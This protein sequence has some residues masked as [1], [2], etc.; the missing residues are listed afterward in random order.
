MKLENDIVLN[1]SDGATYSLSE[2][3]EESIDWWKGLTNQRYTKVDYFDEGSEAFILVAFLNYLRLKNIQL[4]YDMKDSNDIN[5]ASGEDL[6]RIGLYYGVLRKEGT[7][8]TLNA[9]LTLKSPAKETLSFYEGVEAST[10]DSVYFQNSDLIVIN[11][12]EQIVD[13]S[14]TA[15]DTG[16]FGNILAGTLINI[17]SDLGVEATITNITAG[18]DGTSEEDDETYRARIISSK[19]FYPA[20]SV[21]WYTYLAQEV[22]PRAKYVKTSNNSGDIYY[23]YINDYDKLVD[24]FNDDK[25]NI[26]YIN[27]SYILAEELSV[28]EN[29]TLN[30]SAIQGYDPTQLVTDILGVFE[31]YINSVEI[32]GTIDKDYLVTLLYGV[33][34]LNSL[35]P[36]VLTSISL[37]NNQYCTLASTFSVN[38]LGV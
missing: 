26:A 28:F 3:I 7:F 15:E 4:A 25:Y 14:M 6:D 10:N 1:M 8:S 31:E 23:I 9:R 38:V 32:G 20:G 29:S 35:D 34:G 22:S 17:T 24:L 2:E 21:A 30:V 11:S 12:N 33:N 16:E 18:V 13:F 5:E 27:L 37:N 36:S 19:E